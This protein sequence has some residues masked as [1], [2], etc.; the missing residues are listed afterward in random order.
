MGDASTK[1]GVPMMIRAAD[2]AADMLEMHELHGEF[3]LMSQRLDSSIINMTGSLQALQGDMRAVQERLLQVSTQQHDIQSHSTG[4]E[5]LA[6]AIEK[7]NAENTAWRLGHAAEN[8]K[9]AD[10]V[11]HWRGWFAGAGA[12]IFLLASAVVYI[13][14]TGFGRVDEQFAAATSERLRMER[15]KDSDVQ[16]LERL[17]DQQKADIREIQQMGRIK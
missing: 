6:S 7:Q 14:Q 3:R 8:Q 17:I 1:T 10:Q 4:L 9:V 11:S 15:N 2:S 13:V 16:R 12:V 5:R